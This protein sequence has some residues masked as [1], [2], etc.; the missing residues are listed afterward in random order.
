MAKE[1]KTVDE[2]EREVLQSD[3]PVLVDFWA[4]WCG[5]CRMLAPTIEELSQEYEG[6]V[7]VVK[8]NTDELPMV[9]MQYG[10]RGIP[11]VILFV[12]GEPADVKVGL[13]PKA[14]FENMIARF[15]GE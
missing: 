9:A 15:L 13:Q 4:P 12:N 1:I 11:T 8:V 6:K 2:F 14:V 3:I 5:P 10:I 7:K